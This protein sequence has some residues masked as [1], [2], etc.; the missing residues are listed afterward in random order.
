[1]ARCAGRS[2]IC[3]HFGFTKRDFMRVPSGWTTPAYIQETHSAIRSNLPTR[4][5]PKAKII[6]GE[7][8]SGDVCLTVRA[9]ASRDL[10]VVICIALLDETRSRRRSKKRYRFVAR[11]AW[12]NRCGRCCAPFRA[13]TLLRPCAFGMSQPHNGLA[14]DLD[15]P[16]SRC[17]LSEGRHACA[18][19]LWCALCVHREVKTGTNVCNFV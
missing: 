13:P 14:A 10:L 3:L 5:F 4:N 15:A 7:E 6:L 11:V 8:T 19:R 9:Q 18:L 2:R 16:V 17:Q 12:T 1:M